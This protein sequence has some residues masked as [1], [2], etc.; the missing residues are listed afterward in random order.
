MKYYK[1]KTMIKTNVIG[2]R[3]SRDA[4][5]KIKSVSKET[6]ITV[7][8]FILAAINEFIEYQDLINSPKKMDRL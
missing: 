5:N 1:S 4:K 7:S 8:E 3:V 2:V 6:G